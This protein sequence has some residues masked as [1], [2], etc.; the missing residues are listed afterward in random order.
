MIE[1]TVNCPLI[2]LSRRLDYYRY[3]IFSKSPKACLKLTYRLLKFHTFLKILN[4]GGRI[5]L[6]WL[7][8]EFLLPEF[9]NKT[10]IKIKYFGIFGIFLFSILGGED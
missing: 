3:V 4:V 8:L 6:K 5:V 10:Q 1:V 2:D 9:I 7:Y